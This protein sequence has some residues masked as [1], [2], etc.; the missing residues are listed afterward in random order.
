MQKV[1]VSFPEI[2]FVAGTRGLAGIGIGLL[3]ANYLKS[4]ERK[5]LGIA[6]LAIGIL[7]TIPIAFTA[8]RRYMRYR[9]IQDLPKEHTERYNG[10]Q[11][12]AFL[13]AFNGAYP[14]YGHDEERAFEAAHVAARKAGFFPGAPLEDSTV[15]TSS[16]QPRVH[17]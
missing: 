5:K 3:A 6:L 8:N 4:R 13:K 12:E 17:P 16:P 14:K 9:T 15:A 1:N 10:H 7:T 11:K 2:A